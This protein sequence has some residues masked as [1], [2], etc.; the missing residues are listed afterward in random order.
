MNSDAVSS[1]RPTISRE[2]L[3]TDLR[4]LGVQRGELLNLRVSLSSIGHVEGG[5]KTV[6]DAL[7]DVVGP[8]GTL[9]TESFVST[10][11]LPMRKRNA[12]KISDRWTPSYA[13]AVANAM[14]RY[15][16]SYR[17]LHP[18]QKFSAVGAL[19]EELTQSHTADSYA[20]DVL[21]KM[22]EM[23]GH[24]LKIGRD[25][26]VPGVGT[27]HV[28]VGYYLGH[29]QNRPPSGVNYLN[30][31]GEVITFE[32]NW[33]GGCSF[34]FSKFIPLYR[35]AGAIL[36]EGQVGDAPSKITD[37]RGTLEVEIDTLSKDPA[38]FLCDNPL[39]ES[40][41]LS[42]EFSDGSRWILAYHRLLTSPSTFFKR[43]IRKLMR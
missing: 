36:G 38:F 5:P 29:T 7:L 24:N 22:C 18:I 3:V 8:E 42:W 6:I 32:R 19:A 27:S 16:N 13:G 14:I 10:Y 28:A 40:C 17:S 43:A 12:M 25:E 4:K 39:C 20:Y 31:D 21:R 30:E 23:G 11:P 35:D 34:G 15:P 26:K 9:V 2:R 37:M 1:D 33:A 41:R